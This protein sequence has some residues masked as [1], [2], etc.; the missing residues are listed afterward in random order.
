VSAYEVTVTAAGREYDDMVIDDGR[1]RASWDGVWRSAVGRYGWGYVVEM[2]IPIR[3]LRHQSHDTVWGIE[4]GRYDANRDEWTYWDHHR[5]TGFRVSEMGSLVGI[6]PPL[7]WLHGNVKPAASLGLVR[8]DYAGSVSNS[9]STG[10]GLEAEVSPVPNGTAALSL[11]RGSYSWSSGQSNSSANS[12]RHVA[13][14]YEHFLRRANIGALLVRT[15]S[16]A[17]SVSV[18][19][20]RTALLAGKQFLRNSDVTGAC[21]VAFG[22]GPLSPDAALA[23]TLRLGDFRGE[24]G[25][26]AAYS[27]ESLQADLQAAVEYYSSSVYSRASYQRWLPPTKFP[28]ELPGSGGFEQI[29]L[30][31]GPEFHTTGAV[32]D[33]YLRLSAESDRDPSEPF[34]R[35]ALWTALAGAAKTRSLFSWSGELRYGRYPYGSGSDSATSVVAADLVVGRDLYVSQEL[36]FAY[37]QAG[38]DTIWNYGFT[39]RLGPFGPLS[40]ASGSGWTYHNRRY[41]YPWNLPWTDTHWFELELGLTRTM[42]AGLSYEWQHYMVPGFLFPDDVYIHGLALRGDWEFLRRSVLSAAL[43]YQ[44]ADLPGDDQI[45]RTSLAGSAGLLVGF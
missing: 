34:D 31:A 45:S 5:V 40:F 19:R 16:A 6:Q 27:A 38:L 22:K 20:W 30:S 7:A 14:S 42:N 4:F 12:Q 17:D 24:M 35:S 3:M 15:D 43:G 41:P 32:R 25:A 10:I 23:T 18:G 13:L 28:D 26:A 37:S 9:R 2:S 29:A 36:L 21:N 44:S 11:D 33:G 1:T 39:T 8:N